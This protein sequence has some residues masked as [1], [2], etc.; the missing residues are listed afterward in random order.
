MTLI[1]LILLLCA[2]CN[3]T[4]SEK[5]ILYVEF[6]T[7]LKEYHVN[8]S[9]YEES[10]IIGNI[11]ESYHTDSTTLFQISLEKQLPV[12]SK[13][14]F[15]V[16]GLIGDGKVLIMNS[17]KENYYENGDTILGKF[18]APVIEFDTSSSKIDSVLN[19][20]DPKVRDILNLDDVK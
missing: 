6:D 15:I 14:E 16:T 20:L 10:N 9:I 13:V 18:T 5:N 2:S 1:N 17:N 11:T 4:N 19:K 12:D 8:T 3:N 7:T